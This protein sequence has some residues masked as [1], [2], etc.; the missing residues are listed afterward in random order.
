MMRREYP[1]LL[2]ISG[3]P[4]IASAAVRVAEATLGTEA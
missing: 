4:D 2:R 3:D 1:K